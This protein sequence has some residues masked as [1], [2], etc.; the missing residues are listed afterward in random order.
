MWLTVENTYTYATRLTEDERLWLHHFL[1]FEDA[2]RGKDDEP[3]RMYNF[4]KNRFPTG[5]L[6]IVE[7]GA[8]QE[9]YEV[10]RI[11]KRVCPAVLDMDADLDWLTVRKIERNGEEIAY[12]HEAVMCAVYAG[13]GIIRSPT[14]SG[15][16]EKVVG[17]AKSVPIKWLFLVHRSNLRDDICERFNARGDGS[18][19]WR[20]EKNGWRL[21]ERFTVA[22]F[23]TLYRN[24]D[25][26]EVKAMLKEVQGIIVDECHALPAKSHLKV[27]M[28]CPNAYYRIGLSGTPL[29]RGDNKS[30]TAVAALGPICFNVTYRELSA[31]GYVPDPQVT[32]VGCH[33]TTNRR[34]WNAVYDE[35]IVHSRTRNKLLVK[36]AKRARKP[37]VLFVERIAHGKALEEDLQMA[38]LQA[39]FVYGKTK[40]RRNVASGVETGD[41]D[42]LITNGVFQE[43]LD[44]AA[45]R[46]VILGQGYQAKIMMLQR[47]GRGMR[48]EKDASG[49]ILP[50]SRTFEVWDINDTG[51]PWMARHSNNRKKAYLKVG[52]S[53]TMED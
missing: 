27:A 47:I 46:S 6:P 20:A 30:L 12:Q 16:G 53:V 1:T 49:R 45:F 19:A 48:L 33:Q 14:G 24:L 43:G 8:K 31:A 40:G 4:T 23:Q 34:T 50:D 13:R 29:D 35:L 21:A 52:Y 39:Q 51:Q 42:V 15:K 41:L 26:P 18:E 7:K 5:M 3:E 36:L 2:R 38:G 17:I 37:A 10:E 11:D 9:G 25:R 22:T 28:A 44:I 32:F